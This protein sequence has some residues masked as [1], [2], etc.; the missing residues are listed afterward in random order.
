MYTILSPLKNIHH[1]ILMKQ[2]KVLMKQIK[3]LMKQ[4]KVL[5]KQ[6]II[7]MKQIIIL[8]NQQIIL[9][10]QSPLERVQPRLRRSG[11]SGKSP[12]WV[13]TQN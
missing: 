12:D 5:M 1:I 3:V 13:G 10:K 6:I 4:I 2:I 7:L 8:M 11:T 9:V